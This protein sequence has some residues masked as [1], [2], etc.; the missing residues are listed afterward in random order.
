LRPYVCVSLRLK[1]MERSLV[2]LCPVLSPVLTAH[3]AGLRSRVC[4][5]AKKEKRKAAK[6]AEQQP[7]EALEPEPPAANG[8]AEGAGGQP[9]TGNSRGRGSHASY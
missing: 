8:A 1:M 7:P 4:V 2:P 6:A 3:V 5:R 9:E